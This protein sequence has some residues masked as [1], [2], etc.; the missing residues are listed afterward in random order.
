MLIS[1]NCSQ[2]FVKT[3]N[4]NKMGYKALGDFGRGQELEILGI[5]SYK[6]L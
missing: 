2:S 5:N 6:Y 3:S 4:K 1:N